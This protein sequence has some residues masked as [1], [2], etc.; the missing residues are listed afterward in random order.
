MTRQRARAIVPSEDTDVSRCL[1]FVN[2]LSARGSDNPSDQLTSYDALVAWAREKGVLKPDLADR[3]GA[4]ARRRQEDA[5]R[6]LSQARVLRELLH[7]AFTATSAGRSPAKSTMDALS[8]HLSRWYSHGRLVH[9][10][11]AFEWIYA[12]DDDLD[13]IVWEVSRAASRLLTSRRLQRVRPCAAQDCGWW[14]L[15][16][17][18][19][20]SRRWCEMK[21]CG[22][23]E[24]L[25]RFRHRQR[26]GS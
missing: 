9:A 13:R 6:V 14:F 5:G 24:K 20:A 3:L 8:A 11:A 16:D 17:T 12:G 25:R 2:T 7:D 21:T 26:Q 10:D 18:K 19:N 1:A 15:D 22:N 4:R 23:R